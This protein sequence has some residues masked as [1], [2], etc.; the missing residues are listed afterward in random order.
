MDDKLSGLIRDNIYK[1]GDNIIDILSDI[2][3]AIGYPKME[4]KI[5]PEQLEYILDYLDSIKLKV[6]ASKQDLIDIYGYEEE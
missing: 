6:Q 1:G 2:D 5:N 3:L 4:D